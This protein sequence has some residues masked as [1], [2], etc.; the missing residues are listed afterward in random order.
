MLRGTSN[1]ERRAPVTRDAPSR[2]LL[3]VQVQNGIE[4]VTGKAQR[5]AKT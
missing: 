3:L 5:E 2:A 1:A 4:A